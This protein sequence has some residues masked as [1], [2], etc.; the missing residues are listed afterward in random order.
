MPKSAAAEL[1]RFMSRYPAPVASQARAVLARLRK[2]TP[3]ARELVY[4]NYNAL[5]IGFGPTE[6]AS[7]LVLSLA[8]YPRWVNLFF[9]HGASL[10]DPEGL[11][12]G[13]GARV[14]RIQLDGAQTLDLPA[15]RALIAAALKSGPTPFDA[16]QPRALAVKSIS[17]KRRPRR[18]A[19]AT[20]R[21]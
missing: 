14:R 10:P 2:L 3:G 7:D 18:P 6:R 15:V 1:K 4:D 16:R 21:R 13:E 12:Q 11:L 20:G 19:R 9:A 5:V 8:L 17:A